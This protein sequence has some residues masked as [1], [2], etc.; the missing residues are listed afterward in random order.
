MEVHAH[1]HT[2]RKKFTHYLWEFF[3]LF[4]AVTLGFIV[5]N[6]REHL[7]DQKKEK[8]YIQSLLS[9]LK[10]DTI[11]MGVVT[12]AHFKLIRGEDSL[13]DALNNYKDIDSIN[14]QCYRYYFRYATACPKVV[15]NERTMSQLLNSGNMR[16]IHKQSVSD[17]IM[18]Y[19]SVVKYVQ[20][21]GNAYEEYFKKAL[22]FSENIFD[23]GYTQ[24]TLNNDYTVKPK[25]QL[26]KTNFILLSKDPA[27]FKKY[28]N[29]M[30]LLIGV[31]ETYMFT[32]KNAKE[33]AIQL[34]AFLQKEYHLE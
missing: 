34:I 23:F 18:D 12:K 31:L 13:I 9:D 15:F 1:T 21:Q 14:K 5:E 11:I 4:L 20:D 8:N 30:S 3:M 6:M 7:M 27:V 16:L 22:D 29:D 33:K 26:A 24:N 10:K 25:R 28:T 32:V 2:E 17:S 19:N